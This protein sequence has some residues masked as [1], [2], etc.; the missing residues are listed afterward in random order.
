MLELC[1]KFFSDFHFTQSKSWILYDPWIPSNLALFTSLSLSLSISHSLIL[2]QENY[3][4]SSPASSM[5]TRFFI[6]TFATAAPFLHIP[7]R[8]MLLFP[9]GFYSVVTISV[10]PTLDKIASFRLKV[11]F[12]NLFPPLRTSRYKYIIYILYN[13]INLFDLLSHLLIRCK[14]WL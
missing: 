14:Q 8:H 7:I 2:L 6:K 1:P 5:K 13:F 10:I 4:C 11:I 9:S 3:S 12:L